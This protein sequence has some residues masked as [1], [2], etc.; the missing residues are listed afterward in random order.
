MYVLVWLS[1][2]K[3]SAQIIVVTRLLPDGTMGLTAQNYNL[4]F[5]RMD[6][7]HEK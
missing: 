1:G 6:L 4:I 5:T 3:E 2:R 7:V